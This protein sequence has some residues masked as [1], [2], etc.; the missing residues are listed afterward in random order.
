MTDNPFISVII[1]VKNEAILLSRCL[2][3]LKH[4]NY[5][6]EKLEIIIADGLSTDNTRDVA[7]SYGA[8]LV[9]N[10]KQVVGSGRNCG[11]KESKGSLIAFTDADCIFHP[12]WLKNSVKYFKQERTHT[13]AIS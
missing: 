1:P 3:S 10:E 7:L 2:D 13:P 12:D 8:K 11:F 5:P 6:Q 9:A 4:L